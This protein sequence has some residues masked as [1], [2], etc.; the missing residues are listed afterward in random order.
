MIGGPAFLLQQIL[1]PSL[2]DFGAETGP[3]LLTELDNTKQPIHEQMH[4]ELA[5]Q[6]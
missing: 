4:V 2:Y 3:Q 1:I 5:V 6:A